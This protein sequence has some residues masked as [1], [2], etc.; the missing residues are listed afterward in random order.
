M[1]LSIYDLFRFFGVFT[2]V[3][4]SNLPMI[5]IDLMKNEMSRLNSQTDWDFILNT[6]V[7]LTED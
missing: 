6:Q 7:G 2:I 5:V 1:N 4:H 3:L